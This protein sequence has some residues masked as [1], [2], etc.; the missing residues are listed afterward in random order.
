MHRLFHF[1][2]RLFALVLREI[3]ERGNALARGTRSFPAAKGLITGPSARRR[4]LRTINVSDSGLNVVE[5][6]G[7]IFVIAVATGSQSESGIIGQSYG[8]SAI[9]HPTKHGDRYEHLLGKQG[10]RRRRFSQ[11]R[12]DK[13]AV[14][15]F[16]I[17]QT[18][19]AAENA[20]A[21]FVE[22]L[23]ITPVIIQGAGGGHWPEPVLL[24]RRVA[25]GNSGDFFLELF[26]QRIGHF[27]INVD[28]RH[29]RALLSAQTKR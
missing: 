12:R 27:V 28:S 21:V 2:L 5:E 11:S 14:R 10:M 22:F 25:N 24:S 4:P 3:I 13:I 6:V 9:A 18:L 20:P 15:Q 26:N 7:R 29:R 23:T 8:L 17:G 1:C 16:A 19:A